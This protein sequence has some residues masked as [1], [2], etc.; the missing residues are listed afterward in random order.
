MKRIS[1]FLLSLSITFPCYNQEV[2]RIVVDITANHKPIS[3][4]IYGKNNCLSDD[5]GNP[6][7]DDDW[8]KLRDA[9]VALFRESGGNNSTKYNWRLRLS[10][11]PDWYNNVYEHDWDF[12]AQSLQ[13]NIPNAQ[14]MWSFQLLG[15]VAANTANNFSDW[16]YN[17]SQWWEGVSQNL[18]GGGTP[19]ETGGSKA[20]VEG[21]TDLYL[22]DW[23]ADS[24]TAILDHWFGSGGLSLDSNNIR[25][26]NMDNEAEIW[27]GTHNDVMPTQE[28]AEEFMQRYFAVAK[29]ARAKFPGIKLV[30]PVTANEWQWYNWIGGINYDGRS[31]SWLEYFIRRVAEEQQAS[32]IRLLDVLDIHFYPYS[33]NSSELVQYHRVYF[34]K[35]YIFPEANGVKAINGGW[36]NSITKEYVFER[37]RE[38]L[39]GYM[40]ND[41]TVTFGVSETGIALDNA[42]VTAVWYAS[43]L[44]EFM[45]N[46]V[47]L[48]T[49]WSWKNG[50]WEVLHL[51]SRYNM[52]TYVSGVSDDETSVSAYPSINENADSLTVVLVNRSLSETKTAQVSFPYF[53]LD[54]GT[55]KSYSLSNLINSETFVSHAQNALVSKEISSGN[56]ILTVDLPPLSVTSVLLKGEQV[57]TGLG[58]NNAPGNLTFEVY[59]N[60]VSDAANVQFNLNKSGKVTIDI[61]GLAGNPVFRLAEKEMPAGQGSCLITSKDLSDG[62]Y[63]IRLSFD[64]M[65]YFRKVIMS[66]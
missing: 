38:W 54:P 37:C 24:T 28:T 4:Y 44:G 52:P 56:N 53:R 46:G 5:A 33:T 41:H 30:G 32:G 35:T 47:E 27:S 11:H 62:Y 63:I 18:A 60:P 13:Q 1:L 25:Y 65:Q 66:K 12:A 64:G 19:D 55:F 21:D 34:D 17:Q 42:D 10:S 15:K 61:L 26:W 22:Q 58:E 40:G 6:L 9:G 29:A 39:S 36:N 43:T 3:P 8:Q 14:G 59:P 57:S 49:P 31:H 7:G 51:F 16:S 23:P 48:F 20:L 2:V 50:M 45:K